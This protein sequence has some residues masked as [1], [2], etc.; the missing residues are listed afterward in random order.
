M[1]AWLYVAYP[2]LARKR[3]FSGQDKGQAA[4]L[5]FVCLLCMAYFFAPANSPFTPD[6][7][8][9]ALALSVASQVKSA[10]LRP[11]WP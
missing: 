3:I 1:T 10:S 6:C 5:P 11:K 4:R 8:R 7:S 9:S 2:N